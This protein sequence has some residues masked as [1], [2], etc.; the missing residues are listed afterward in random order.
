LQE[1]K[2]DALKEGKELKKDSKTLYRIMKD[3]LD[4]EINQ[5]A[6]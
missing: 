6:I 1:T 4:K 5:K 3:L 2:R